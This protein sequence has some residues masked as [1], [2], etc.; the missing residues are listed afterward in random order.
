MSNSEILI[1]PDGKILAHNITPVLAGIL[2][3]LNPDDEV[4]SRRAVR[5]RALKAG[6]L[7]QIGESRGG[8]AQIENKPEMPRVIS[9]NSESNL[10]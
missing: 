1:L 6:P 8:E 3:E 4:M 5:P 2:T 9:S 10:P 7:S